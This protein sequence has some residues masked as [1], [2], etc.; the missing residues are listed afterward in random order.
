MKVTRIRVTNYRGLEALD[1]EIRP[2]GAIAK[3]SNAIGKTTVLRSLG[4]ALAARGISPEDIRIG[5]DRAEIL[6]DLDGL[7]VKRVITPKAST[8]TVTRDGMK[9]Q[10]PQNYLTELLGG[11][12]IDPLELFLE[13]DKKKRRATILA[14]LPVAVTIEQI[15]GW[16]GEPT[17]IASTEGHGL[18]VV[19][20]VRDLFYERRTEANRVAVEANGAAERA[21]SD[22]RALAEMLPPFGEPLTVEVARA[23]HEAAR[24][25]IMRLRTQ[26][27]EALKAGDRAAG[28]RERVARLLAEAADVRA[29]ALGIEPTVDDVAVTGA[30]MDAARAEVAE[31]ERRLADARARLARAEDGVRD[32]ERR[33]QDAAAKAARAKAL[34]A[35]ADDLAATIAET[36]AP[37]PTADVIAAAALA[38]ASAARALESAQISDRASAATLAAHAKRRAAN[39]AA[40]AADR[41]DTIVRRLSNEAPAELLASAHA[42]PGLSIDGDDVVL[43]GKRLDALSGA[44]QMR[45]AVDVAKRLNA[46]SKILVVDGLERLDPLACDE[47][48]RAATSDGFQLLASKVAAGEMVIE[49][50]E[51]EPRVYAAE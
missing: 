7:S 10:K 2:A 41:L 49:A 8:L 5:A 30:T 31:L 40:D 24:A 13:K 18:E 28:A 45:F 46:K 27:E 34:T 39:D 32:V 14:A 44:E 16:T 20:R 29:G 43:D 42:I 11:A 36:S 17:F 47:F 26:T 1:A 9:A 19:S 48:V 37:A 22:A 51:C 38:E 12:A 25:D 4:A 6:V 3:G 15:R 35:Q 21:E 50:I 23:R 33:R